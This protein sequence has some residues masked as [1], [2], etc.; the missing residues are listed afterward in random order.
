[1]TYLVGEC[2]DEGEVEQA[3]E[4]CLFCQ[5]AAGEIPVVGGLIYEDEQVYGYHYASD[6]I[7]NDTHDTHDTN[8]T[9]E[10]EYLGHLLVATKRHA[11]D[12]A[13]LTPCEAKSVGLALKRLS[14]ALRISAHVTKVY[15]E[16]YGEVTPHLHIHL[17]ARYPETPP[18][19][20]RWEIENWPDAPRGDARRISAL[21][22]QLRAT[23]AN[24]A[25]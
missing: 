15:A 22:E 10:P 9:S 18:T 5:I 16:F 1:M 20:L 8:A 19:Y 4:N 17:T 24:E 25:S 7:A 6:A 13:D 11:P 23:L 14:S 3:M 12:L 21:S 2:V